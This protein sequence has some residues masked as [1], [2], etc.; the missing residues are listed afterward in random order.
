MMIDEGT[1]AQNDMAR[2]QVKMAELQSLIDEYV[3]VS[4]SVMSGFIRCGEILNRK[5]CP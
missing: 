2:R 3:K 1:I 5:R 4:E